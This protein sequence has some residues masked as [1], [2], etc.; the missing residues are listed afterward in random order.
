[1]TVTVAPVRGLVIRDLSILN[2]KRLDE[3]KLDLPPPRMA[4]DLDVTVLGS[5]NG[6]GKTSVLECI[7]L[8]YLAAAVGDRLLLDM[9]VEWFVDVADLLISS[10][11]NATRISG[12][13]ASAGESREISLELKRRSVRDAVPELSVEGSLPMDSAAIRRVRSASL[14]SVLAFSSEPLVAPPLLFF[15]SHRKVQE[16]NPD[17]AHMAEHVP[18]QERLRRRPG[19]RYGLSAVSG[20]KMEMLRSILGGANLFEGLDRADSEKILHSLNSLLLR[21]AGGTVDK[22]RPLPDNTLDLRIVTPR[23]VSFA[24]DGLSAGQKEIVST[25]FLIWRHSQEGPLLVLIDEPELHLN[26]EWHADF[27]DQLRHAGPGN[28]YILAT[29]SEQVFGSVEPEHR[30]LLESAP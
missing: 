12:T 15:N 6:G 20:F 9:G 2:Y 13:F 24:F 25:L 26:A 19:V 17:L 21:Y 27:V 29:H 14:A 23:G 22:M 4:H 28:Q 8:L 5:K 16:G 7:A 1:M 3:L 11:A 10:E 30:I 18:L